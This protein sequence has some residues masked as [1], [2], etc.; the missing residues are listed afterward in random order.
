MDTATRVQSQ[1]EAVFIPHSAYTLRK[2]MN[3]TI[4]SAAVDKIVGQTGL[5]SL[6]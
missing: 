2:G 4:L 3:P 5:F 6:V 1:D